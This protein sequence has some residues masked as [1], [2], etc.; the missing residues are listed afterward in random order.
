[1]LTF[2]KAQ[3]ASVSA[4]AVDFLVTI[5]SVEYFGRWYM[6]GTVMGTISGGL[7][8]FSL[9][10]GWVFHSDDPQVL[11]QAAR[12]FLIWNGS[13]LL[14]AS[15]V[16][17]ITHYAGVSYVISK[18]IASV[19]VGVGFNYPMH[20]KFVFRPIPN[21]QPLGTWKQEKK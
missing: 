10:R 18:V 5:F 16:F 8:H 17:V 13:L 1:M 15:G 14:N 3:T 19:M 21:P 12:Y 4:T 2:L 20:K 7:T 11:N 6:L 9:G